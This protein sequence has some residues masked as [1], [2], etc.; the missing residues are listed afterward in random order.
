MAGKTAGDT[1]ATGRSGVVG[2]GGRKLERKIHFFFFFLVANIGVVQGVQA[3]AGKTTEKVLEK[4]EY[5]SE[6]K[7]HSKYSRTRVCFA[8]F[9]FWYFFFCFTESFFVSVISHQ[10]PRHF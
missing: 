7:I 8:F 4:D 9:V 3:G 5:A 2:C 6:M 1:A 10:P